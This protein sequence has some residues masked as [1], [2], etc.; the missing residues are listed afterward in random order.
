LYSFAEEVLQYTPK[1]ICVAATLIPDIERLSR[2][3][4]DF[5]ER[6]CKLQIPVLIGGR[7]FSDE[8]L[9]KRFPAEFYAENFTDV[10]KFVKR[11]SLEN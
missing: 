9:R 5:R 6:I 10:V 2:D 3:Y 1:I 7:A 4:K 11:I 8:Q